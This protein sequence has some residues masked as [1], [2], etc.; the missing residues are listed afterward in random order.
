MAADKTPLLSKLTLLVLLLILGCLI[1]LIAQQYSKTKQTEAE[2]N[3]D[4]SRE[5]VPDTASAENADRAAYVR[6]I[7]RPRPGSAGSGG[8]ERTGVA[9]LPRAYHP[10]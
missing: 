10:L 8:E 3:S 9:G 4:N 5:M 6:V 7:K 1:I 2:R